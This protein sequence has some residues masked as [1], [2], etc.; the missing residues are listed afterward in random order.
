[1]KRRCT[2]FLFIH[3]LY[4][5]IFYYC[6][7][8]N[9]SAVPLTVGEFDWKEKVGKAAIWVQYWIYRKLDL[10]FGSIE[11]EIAVGFTFL[12]CKKVIATGRRFT[13]YTVRKRLQRDEGLSSTLLESDC[14][15]M[16]IYPIHCQK[17]YCWIFHTVWKRLRGMKIC[18]LH[19]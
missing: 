16:K 19:C 18:L 12:H 14:K 4:N 1:M 15:G 7:K 3:N 17:E 8:K 10:K 5:R 11:R 9:R 13:L 2:L 6:N